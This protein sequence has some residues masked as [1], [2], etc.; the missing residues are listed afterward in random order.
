MTFRNFLVALDESAQ[1]A[2]GIDLAIDL[3]KA[4]KAKITLVH[5]LDPAVLATSADDVGS[6]SVM[7]IELDEL[8]AAGKEL[9]ETTA[10]RVR[11]AGLEVETIVRDGVPAKVILDTAMRSNCDL[12]VM[13]THGRHGIER[14]FL[15]SCAEQVLREAAIPVLVKRS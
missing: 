9:V 1:A 14:F 6:T 2:A 3:A 12:I 11:E 8:Q 4:V 5:A 15:G 7:E 10:A 13:G